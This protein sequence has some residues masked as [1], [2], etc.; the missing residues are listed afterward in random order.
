MCVRDFGL[1]MLSGLSVFFPM[2]FIL[3][4]SSE[5]MS[6]ISPA[7]ELK[8]VVTMGVNTQIVRYAILQDGS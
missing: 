1:I 5:L 7:L 2:M 8:V 3:C 6:R 4:P